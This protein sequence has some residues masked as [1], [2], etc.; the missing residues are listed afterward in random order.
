MGSV[1]NYFCVIPGFLPV[2]THR[3]TVILQ[4]EGALLLQ[5]IKLPVL[6]GPPKHRAYRKDQNQ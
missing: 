6:Q 4:D 1:S 5:I 3:I 2:R